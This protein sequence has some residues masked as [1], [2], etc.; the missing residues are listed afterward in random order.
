ME[1]KILIIQLVLIHGMD[2]FF[3]KTDHSNHSNEQ[4]LFSTAK[5][6]SLVLPVTPWQSKWL[7]SL[8]IAR[9]RTLVLLLS[10]MV[11]ANLSARFPVFVLIVLLVAAPIFI[12][13]HTDGQR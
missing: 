1:R 9:W 5:S 4:F 7:T 11:M 3:L 2:E 10:I 8:G 6:F 12:V 13:V